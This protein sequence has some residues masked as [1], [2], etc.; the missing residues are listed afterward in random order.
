MVSTACPQ[1][2]YY[3]VETTAD[4]QKAVDYLR[5]KGVGVATFLILEKQRHLASEMAVAFKADGMRLFDLIAVSEEKYRVA[6][7]YALRN[8]LVADSLDMASKLAYADRSRPQRVVTV[9]GELIEASGTMS[10]GGAKP[11]EGRMRLGAGGGKAANRAASSADAPEVTKEQL[12]QME[13][14]IKDKEPELRRW[15]GGGARGGAIRAHHPQA[16]G[17]H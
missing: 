3:V 13:K 12:V 16:A 7:Y 6:F 17:V 9:K 14:L 11:M 4:A 10:G 8:T 5:T 2:N 1:L 15:H